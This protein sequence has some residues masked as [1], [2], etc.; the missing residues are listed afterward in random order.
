MKNLE[1]IEK[2]SKYAVIRNCVS[3]DDE[4]IALGGKAYITGE[5]ESDPKSNKLHEITCEVLSDYGV[6]TDEDVVVVF[7]EKW[8]SKI[9]AEIEEKLNDN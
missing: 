5:F 6:D 7:D 3:T 8:A 2:E 4:V 1:I 9:D